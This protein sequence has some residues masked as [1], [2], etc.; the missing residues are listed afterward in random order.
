MVA[1][2]MRADLQDLQED[3]LDHI[4]RRM[5]DI[6]RRLDLGR[7]GP[8]VRKQEDGVVKSLDKLIKKLEDQEKQRQQ[9]A[10]AANLT[11]DKPAEVSGIGEGKGPGEVTKTQH[12]QQKRLGQSATQ[13]A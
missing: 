7:A 10:G 6:H 5:D 4:A 12:R 11:P 2:L 8:K 3:T 1:Q 9:A 13:G